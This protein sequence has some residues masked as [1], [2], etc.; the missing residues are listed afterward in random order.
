MPNITALLIDSREPS[1]VQSLK[2]N[3]LPVMVTILDTGDVQAVTDDGHTLVIERKTPDDFLNTLKE[4]R[5]FP[6]VAKMIEVSRWS[7]LV[8]TGLFQCNH[9]GKVITDRGVTGW[10]FAAVMGT[11][12]SIQEMGVFVVFANGDSDYEAAVLR[13]GK[14]NRDAA[15]TVVPARVPNVLGPKAMFLLS[16]PGIG[17]E[18]VQ[19]IL[20][21][22]GNNVFHALMGMTD[23]D[24]DS[25]IG[26]AVRKRIR[27]LMGLEDGI[28]MMPV[29]KGE[30]PI[31]VQADL[32]KL[33][34][35]S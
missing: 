24:I 8:I 3:G 21:W 19:E 35:K 6:Q 18:R 10:N 11:L 4:E 23:L 28:N 14:R 13:L 5:L 26:M 29:P 34:V 32:S 15:M 16:L 22:S 2:F 27:D 25:P 30:M 7:Y 20:D 9:E 31:P 1:W 33:E 12:L 17:I